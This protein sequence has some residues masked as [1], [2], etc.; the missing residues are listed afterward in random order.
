MRSFAPE[1]Y[2]RGAGGC[3]KKQ[4][5]FLSVRGI[6]TQCAFCGGNLAFLT[7]LWYDIKAA[8]PSVFF[9]PCRILRDKYKKNAVYYF[10]S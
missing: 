7:D 2:T 6:C 3:N 5:R 4:N 8:V 9:A 1:F 10:C